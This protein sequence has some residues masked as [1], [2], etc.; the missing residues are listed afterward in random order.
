MITNINQQQDSERNSNSSYCF[1]NEWW[2]VAFTIALLVRIPT[3]GA[4][5][6]L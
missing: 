1:V 4:G 3:P 6:K 5:D 2:E